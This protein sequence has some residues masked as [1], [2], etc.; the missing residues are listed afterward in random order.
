MAR[1]NDIIGYKSKCLDENELL[2]NK[3]NAKTLVELEKKK[4]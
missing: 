4:D 1:L 3:V 2:K